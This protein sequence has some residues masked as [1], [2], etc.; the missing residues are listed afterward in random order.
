MGLPKSRLSP[1][2]SV[3]NAA[4]RLIAHLPRFT[5]ISTYM[6]EVLHWLWLPLEL[7][8]RSSSLYPKPQLG[9]APSYLTDFM[10]KPMSSTSA[11]PLRS[12]DRLDLFVPRAR[13]ALVQSCAFAVT[14]LSSWN[15]LPH[16][17]RAKLMLISGISATSCHSL[18]TF[19]FP[20]ELPR[21]NAS[22]STGLVN[23]VRGAL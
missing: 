17:L 21:W 1:I 7:N 15:G 6:T 16:L 20:L 14:G 2:Q 22:C 13:T 19:L 5:H 23:A 8:S 18:K 4:A 12:A 10:C 11:H 9:L 3:L